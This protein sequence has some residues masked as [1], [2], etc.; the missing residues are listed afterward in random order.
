MPCPYYYAT[1]RVF[2]LKFHGA[3]LFSS[4]SYTKVYCSTEPAHFTGTLAPTLP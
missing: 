1:R 3:V 2:A 4:R